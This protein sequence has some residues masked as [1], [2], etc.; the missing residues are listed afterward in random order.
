MSYIKVRLVREMKSTENGIVFIA[1]LKEGRVGFKEWYLTPH[2]LNL[3]HVYPFISYDD[4][5]IQHLI[6]SLQY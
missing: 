5:R 6:H 3:L 2:W 1:R 4:I